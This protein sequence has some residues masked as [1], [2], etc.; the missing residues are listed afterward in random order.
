M[1]IELRRTLPHS[2]PIVE[3]ALLLLRDEQAEPSVTFVPR[4]DTR[5]HK[6]FELNYEVPYLL[7]PFVGS[8]VVLREDIVFSNA[9]SCLTVT[10]QSENYHTLA[11]PYM[12]TETVYSPGTSNDEVLV[13]TRVEWWLREKA[14]P[15]EDTLISFGKGKYENILDLLLEYC[16]RVR[17]KNK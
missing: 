11:F 16:E 17:D 15:M 6:V 3:E 8:S 2:L 14:L 5:E 12:Y 10:T 1:K 13:S 7:Y 9:S 4:K